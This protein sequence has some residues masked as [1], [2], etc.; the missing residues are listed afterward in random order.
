[1]GIRVGLSAIIRRL[2]AKV[3]A[4]ASCLM[5]DLHWPLVMI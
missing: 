5:A 4:A 2:C 3:K 1:M